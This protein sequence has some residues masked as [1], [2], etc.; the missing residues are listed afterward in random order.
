MKIALVVDDRLRTLLLP[1]AGADRLPA[2]F[3][4]DEVVF[5][6]KTELHATIVGG[7]AQYPVRALHEA[8]R[9]AA[10]SV[11]PRGVYRLVRKEERRSIVELAD[12]EGLDGLYTRLEAALGVPRGSI[13]RPPTHVTLFTAGDPRGRGIA[14]YTQQELDELSTSLEAS[15][16]LAA[17]RGSAKKN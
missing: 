6:R 9:G 15:P 5:M 7:R 11:H 10:L 8:L 13:P 3:V 1:L 4:S 17:W 2:T 14:L 12:V 16:A